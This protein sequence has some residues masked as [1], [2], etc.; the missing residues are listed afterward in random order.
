[1]D[2]Y[3]V[4]VEVLKWLGPI[5]L[6]TS[7]G[8]VSSRWREVS[9]SRELWLDLLPVA[10]DLGDSC[11]KR[12]YAAH[13][14]KSVYVVSNNSLKRYYVAAK[15]WVEKPLSRGIETNWQTAMTLPLPHTL[16]VC[17]TMSRREDT[18]SINTQTGTVRVLGTL[19]PHRQGV[20]LISVNGIV[21][22]FGGVN[23]VQANKHDL[24]GIMWTQISGSTV[25][26]AYFNP[27]LKGEIVYLLGGTGEE[28]QGEKYNVHTGNFSLMSLKLEISA[29]AALIHNKDLIIITGYEYITRKLTSNAPAATQP[30]PKPYL[31]P[32]FYSGFDPVIVDNKAFFLH[33]AQA[34]VVEMDLTA[35]TWEAYP[36]KG[37]I[38][39]KMKGRA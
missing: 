2:S 25:K 37:E 28:A 29:C 18:C 38:Q 30:M 23:T 15:I 9:D 8:E 21:Y 17:G 22:A 10:V 12:Y 1:M 33:R 13:F 14:T 4:L 34:R 27:C 7:T 5:D 26:R 24:K 16:F 36:Y 35:F 20:G 11:P 19:N 31:H 32:S 3:R 39:P 6:L